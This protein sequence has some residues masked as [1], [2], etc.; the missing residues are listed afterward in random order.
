LS[1]MEFV[2]FMESLQLFDG[3]WSRMP[4]KRNRVLATQWYLNSQDHI[5][6]LAP[7]VAIDIQP[8]QELNEICIKTAI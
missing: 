6:P 8:S 3:K 5:T 2:G 1:R 4:S 7:S